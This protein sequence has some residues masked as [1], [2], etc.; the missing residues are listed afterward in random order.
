[1]N[2]DIINKC[3]GTIIDKIIWY[4]HFPDSAKGRAFRCNLFSYEQFINSSFDELERLAWKEGGP[5][6]TFVPYDSKD[7][8][9]YHG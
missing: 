2:N 4:A 7:N 8:K 5:Q 9:G 3:N 6:G 1:M